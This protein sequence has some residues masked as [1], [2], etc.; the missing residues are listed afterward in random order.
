M[1]TKVYNIN[2]MRPAFI[3]M[4]ENGNRGTINKKVCSELGISETF[5]EW[6]K[7]GIESLFNAVCNYCRLKNSP[8]A[9][10]AELTA[11]HEAIFPL[12]KDML[13]TAEKSREERELR[14]RQDDVSNLVSFCQTFVNDAN[15]VSRGKDENFVAHKV[16]AVQPIKQFQKKVEIDLGIRIKEIEVMSDTER[17]F[18]SAERKILNQW[19]KAERRIEEVSANKER[20]MAV[21]AKMKSAEAKSLLDEQIS[22]L[23]ALIVSLTDK[24]SKLSQEHHDLLNPPVEAAEVSA[25]EAVADA[26]TPKKGAR[27][28]KSA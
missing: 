9:T 24:V 20:L 8:K 14:V 10:A 16:W 1:A 18:L 22:E 6:Y 28:K 7:K 13:H 26:P 25:P 3:K 21:K 2:A 27:K 17:D 19:K 4:Y 15:D 11:A 5:Y 12:W 23:D